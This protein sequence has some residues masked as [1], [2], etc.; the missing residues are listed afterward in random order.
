[1]LGLCGNLSQFYSSSN[2]QQKFTSVYVR[3]MSVPFRKAS[4]GAIALWCHTVMRRVHGNTI[5]TMARI[6]LLF[7]ISRAGSM[8]GHYLRT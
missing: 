2:V 4:R 7:G 8:P 6:S 3:Q 5:N 1:M